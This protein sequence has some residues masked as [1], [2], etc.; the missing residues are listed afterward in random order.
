MQKFR[1]LCVFRGF[2]SNKKFESGV[3]GCISDNFLQY[4]SFSTT[5][6]SDHHGLD[7]CFV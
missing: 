2:Y 1:V 6:F 4:V 7:F 5:D 3:V